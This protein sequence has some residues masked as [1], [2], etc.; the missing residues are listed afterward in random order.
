MGGTSLE[1]LEGGLTKMGVKLADAAAGTNEP[2]HATATL[3]VAPGAV[4]LHAASGEYVAAGG[5]PA[6]VLGTVDELRVRVDIDE[7]DAWRVRPV[8]GRSYTFTPANP[9]PADPPAVGGTMR[10]ST[11]VPSASVR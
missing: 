10:A 9:R 2:E 3:H 6:L 8:A 7:N 11:I 1:S 4:A 5:G